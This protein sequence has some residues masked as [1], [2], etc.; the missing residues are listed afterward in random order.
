ML[1]AFIVC[2]NSVWGENYGDA[3]HNFAQ[4]LWLIANFVWM[5]GDFHDARYPNSPSVYDYRAQIS[6]DVM[7]V[8]LIWL[9]VYYFFLR[10]FNVFNERRDPY[11]RVTE[12]SWISNN[13][14]KN[15]K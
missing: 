1:L 4:L 2:L 9:G 10:P 13:I 12:K 7:L 14:F 5:T 8:A 15:W 11:C 3:W 6:Q